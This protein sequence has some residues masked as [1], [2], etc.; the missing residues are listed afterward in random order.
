MWEER[1]KEVEQYG[2]YVDWKYRYYECPECGRCVYEFDRDDSLKSFICPFCGFEGE[3]EDEEKDFEI[4]ISVTY[5]VSAKTP[6]QAKEFASEM[7]MNNINC[8]NFDVDINE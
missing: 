7:F 5:T 1:A 6:E 8:S 2:G 3:N 4:T